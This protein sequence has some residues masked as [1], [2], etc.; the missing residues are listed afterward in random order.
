M[1]NRYYGVAIG[2]G[3]PT[4]VAEAASTTSRPIELTVDLTAA[5]ADKVSVLKALRALESY[6]TADAWPPA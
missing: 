6:I 5:G 2:G 1:A 4:E 3:M